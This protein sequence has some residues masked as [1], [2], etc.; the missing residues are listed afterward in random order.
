LVIYLTTGEDHVKNTWFV[1]KVK[2]AVAKATGLT[3]KEIKE[4]M[5]GRDERN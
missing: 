1:E 2:A 5:E 3:W 4:M